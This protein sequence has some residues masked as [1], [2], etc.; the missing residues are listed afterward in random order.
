MRARPVEDVRMLFIAILC[1]V[2]WFLGLMTKAALPAHRRLTVA[3]G[4][5]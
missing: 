2:L 1:V 4:N 3:R 5:G